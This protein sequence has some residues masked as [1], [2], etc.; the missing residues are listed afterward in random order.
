MGPKGKKRGPAGMV[1]VCPGELGDVGEAASDDVA[2]ADCDGVDELVTAAATPAPAP[3]TRAATPVI[4]SGRLTRQRGRPPR[5]PIEMVYHGG[6]GGVVPGGD[7][8]TDATGG[9]AGTEAPGVDPAG[10]ASGEF[11]LADGELMTL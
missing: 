3:T 11:E 5:G 8:G 6:P 1:C 2:A 7:A 4:T 9:D 10:V